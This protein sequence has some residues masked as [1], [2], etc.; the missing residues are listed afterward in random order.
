VFTISHA[1]SV[2]TRPII[3]LVIV[4]LPS[5]NFVWFPADIIIS[6]APYAIIA[7]AITIASSV[8]YVMMF[9]E[10]ITASQK[11][12]GPVGPPVTMA[13]PPHFAPFQMFCADANRGKERNAA[14]EKKNVFLTIILS[15]HTRRYL[16]LRLLKRA[17]HGECVFVNRLNRF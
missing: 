8:R 2:T 3:A 14:S 11:L 16:I 7:T 13:M 5:A 9:D 4:D 1:E 12:H 10:T 15:Y 17:F 6:I